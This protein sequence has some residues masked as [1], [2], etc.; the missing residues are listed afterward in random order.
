MTAPVDLAP[1]YTS[2]WSGRFKPA[3]AHCNAVL[4]QRPN[5]AAALHLKGMALFQLGRARDAI[6]A[7]ERAVAAAPGDAAAIGNLG[8][9]L[10][11]TRRS[12]APRNVSA[13]RPTSIPRRSRSMRRWAIC[14]ACWAASAK[15]RTLAGAPSN[16][17]P[18]TGSP[19]ST[20]G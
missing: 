8:R 16:S 3:L 15:R 18:P 20:W 19:T 4:K 14:C 9:M 7:V 13:R 6:R 1:A 17:R 2:F 5:D 11:T 12:N 10:V